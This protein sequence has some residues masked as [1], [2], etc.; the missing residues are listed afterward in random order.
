MSVKTEALVTRPL[1]RPEAS[2]E[3][4]THVL[5]DTPHSMHI[6][7]QEQQCSSRAVPSNKYTGMK[8]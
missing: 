2:G 4:A 5:P 7:M 8:T 1:R 3:Y 6:T